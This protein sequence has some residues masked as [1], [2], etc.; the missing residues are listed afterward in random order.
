VV[1]R[2]RPTLDWIIQAKE[3]SPVHT[4]PDQSEAP[5]YF[6]KYIEMVPDG[7][8]REILETQQAATMALF[9]SISDAGSLHRYA[10]DKW[11]IRELVGHI[12]DT[13]RVFAFRAF[14][15]ARGFPSPLPSFDQHIAASGAAA[16]ERSWSSHVDEF[17]AVRTATLT[18]FHNLPPAAWSRSGTADGRHITVRALAYIVAGHVVHHT[19]VLEERYLRAS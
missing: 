18:F 19:T 12:N 2:P 10:A 5:D 8:V 17:R 3:E 16:G 9:G 11:N 4:R 14:W 6:W 1:A 15:F 7:D 13:E